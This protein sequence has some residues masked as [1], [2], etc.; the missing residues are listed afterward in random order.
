MRFRGSKDVLYK[1]IQFEL[2]HLGDL[3]SVWHLGLLYSDAKLLKAGAGIISEGY[4]QFSVDDILLAK[5]PT[6]IETT[7]TKYFSATDSL[8]YQ[9]LMK[10]VRRLYA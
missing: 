8:Y 6:D 3:T 7:T 9:L 10:E 2:K 4:T 1:I 5:T